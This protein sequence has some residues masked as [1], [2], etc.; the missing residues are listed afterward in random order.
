MSKKIYFSVCFK[1]GLL[2]WRSNLKCVRD[3]R[4]VAV[5]E[6]A[7]DLLSARRCWKSDNW[8]CN[9]W[10]KCHLE[11]LEEKFARY[12]ALEMTK[13]H[14][15]GSAPDHVSRNEYNNTRCWSRQW[16]KRLQAIAFFMTTI[17]NIHSIIVVQWTKATWFFTMST[18]IILFQKIRAHMIPMA[19]TLLFV[20]M[21]APQFDS[22]RCLFRINI[23]VRSRLMG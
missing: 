12:F 7:P 9:W 23:P 22:S 3:D 5:A 19:A 20:Y 17:F 18:A 13:T 15:I 16:L 8:I 11:C 1:I 21:T 14:W 2:I 10:W 6:I 4:V